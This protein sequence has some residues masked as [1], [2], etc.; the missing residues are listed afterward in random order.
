MLKAELHQLWKV[1][2]PIV[3]QSVTEA[4]AQG[5]RSENAEYIYGKKRLREID[6]RVRYLS[7]R[8][9]A[10]TVVSQ[11]PSNQCKVFFGAYIKLENN[12]GVINEYRIVGPD[13]LDPKKGY[14]SIDGPL[15][16]ALLGKEIDDEVKITSPAGV[17]G[18][19]ILGV[20]YDPSND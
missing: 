9:E 5:D 17:S 19:V 1:E 20:R 18:Y 3:T 15:A 13:E 4:A 2:R 12:D 6:H 14:I 11:P 7:K 8:L 16:R 10:F